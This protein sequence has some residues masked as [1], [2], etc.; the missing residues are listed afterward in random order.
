MSAKAKKRKQASGFGRAHQKVAEP[1]KQSS[2]MER[3]LGAITL[4]P[5]IYRE[6]AHD[7]KA[8]TQAAIIVVA[9]ALIVGVI[10]YIGKVDPSLSGTASSLMGPD[11]RNPLAKAIVFVIQELLIWFGAAWVIAAVAHGYFK[12]NTNTGE[13]LR[14]FGY[15]RIFQILLVLGVFS[16]V[17]AQITSIAGFVLSITAAVIGIKAATDFSTG[18]AALIGIFSIVLGAVL[19]SFFATFV[20]NPMVAFLLPS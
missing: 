9:V 4:K 12:G 6:I 7:T 17:I 20:L 15:S 3:L 13:M 16:A 14:V 8:T 18:K 10:A 2:I 5:E 11:K 19:V 1:E